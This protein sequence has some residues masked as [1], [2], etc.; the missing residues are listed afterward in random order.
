[1]TRGHRGSLALRR[2]AFSSPSPCRFIPAHHK[3]VAHPFVSAVRRAGGFELSS[4]WRLLHSVERGRRIPSSTPPRTPE[5]CPASLSVARGGLSV[6]SRTG[7][8]SPPPPPS[9]PIGA[10]WKWPRPPSPPLSVDLRHGLPEVRLGAWVARGPCSWP[11][12]I[13]GRRPDGSTLS[14]GFGRAG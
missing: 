11:L 5:R 8:P 14:F 6:R 2:R 12:G 3:S 9:S 1:M 10:A 7:I 4:L 13:V